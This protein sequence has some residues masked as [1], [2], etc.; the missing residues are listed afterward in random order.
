M[1]FGPL[2]VY[3]AELILA[4]LVLLVSLPAL[5]GSFIART[6]QTFALA[7]LA[8]AVL[9][10]VVIG[11]HWASGG[12][13][14][15][16]QFIPSG[17]AYFLVCLHCTS[18][19]KL[20]ILVLMLLSVCLF[21]IANGVIELRD[22]GPAVAN[23]HAELRADPYLLPM[24]ND[25]GVLTYRLRGPG[26]IN[27]PNDF[28]QLVACVIPLLFISW[29][30]KNIAWNIAAVLLPVGVLLYGAFLTHSRGTLLAL[31]A[32]AVVA[33]RKRIGLIPSLVLG[34]ALFAGATASNFTGGRGISAEAGADRTSL[35]GIGMEM[36]KSHP[37]FGVGFGNFAD[38]A[39]LTAH[40][41]VVVCAAELGL[42]G[43]FFW[44]LF[45]ST[46]VRDAIALSA[47][48]KAGQASLTPNP[49]PLV[50]GKLE[51]L[52][53]AE[54]SRLGGL[55]LVS[56]TGFL[57]TGWFL[58]RSFVV[59]LYLLGGIVEVI[60]E[61]ALREGMVA[62]RLR[63]GRSIMYAAGWSILLL[64]LMYILLRSVHYSS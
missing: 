48:A 22:P 27:D 51:T 19:K 33:A 1:I 61:M 63:I 8:F 28:G 55:V 40:N 12:I 4:V 17:F 7:G 18:K 36:I 62:P 60:Y 15:F 37:L 21:V 24:G 9:M 29:S 50:S 57:V 16:L 58:S 30:R 25:D 44:T 41:S 35:W 64:L 34:V 52:D 20:Q 54:V 39:G 49:I 6:P 46:T 45:V 14:A 47:P 53:K 10:S 42:F 2:A 13:A 43:F 23:S 56:L 38:Y 59:T 5:Q 31:V 11:Q 26:E 32:M 3:R